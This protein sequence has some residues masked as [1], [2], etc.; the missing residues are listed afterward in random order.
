MSTNRLVIFTASWCQACP[1][2]LEMV[3]ASGIPHEVID[4]EEEGATKEMFNLGIRSVPATVLYEGEE[5]IYVGT[6]SDALASVR[7]LL[8]K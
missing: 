5:P 8:D 3:K 4:T 2:Y 6:G 1:A 7:K